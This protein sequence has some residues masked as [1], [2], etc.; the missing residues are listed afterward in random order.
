[1]AT[2]M[3]SGLKERL[4]IY[5]ARNAKEY[6]NDKVL[7]ESFWIA[8]ERRDFMRQIMKRVRLKHFEVTNEKVEKQWMP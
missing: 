6:L 3:F 1:M 8:N 7:R 2:K 4:N 5:Y